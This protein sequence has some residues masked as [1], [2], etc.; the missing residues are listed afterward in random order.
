MRS[1]VTILVVCLFQTNLIFALS[2]TDSFRDLNQN[3]ETFNLQSDAADKNWKLYFNNL[4]KRYYV[5]DAAKHLNQT[6]HSEFSN[7]S[8]GVTPHRYMVQEEIK[9]LI[10]ERRQR[11][12][13]AYNPNLFHGSTWRCAWDRITGVHNKNHDSQNC[14]DAVTEYSW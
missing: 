11:N 5:K 1:I 2:F 4:D 8:F 12:K 3:V 10:E 9:R 14:I 6:Y 7:R 13:D